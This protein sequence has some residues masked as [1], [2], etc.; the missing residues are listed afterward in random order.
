[1]FLAWKQNKRNLV[2]VSP[3]WVDA[4]TPP[5]FVNRATAL[6]DLVYGYRSEDTTNPHEGYSLML[7]RAMMMHRD[8][9]RLYTCG[10]TSEGLDL[11]VSS[12]FD[13]LRSL[14]LSVVEAEFNCED[15]GMN[16]IVNAAMDSVLSER[17]QAAPLFVRPLHKIGD[18][19]KM[20]HTGLHQKKS[21]VSTRSDCVNQ[22]NRALWR[23]TGRNLPVQTKLVDAVANHQN[24]SLAALAVRPYYALTTR[25]HKDCFSIMD[26]G[27]GDEACSWQLPRQSDYAGTYS[28]PQL[29]GNLSHCDAG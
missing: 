22:M 3:R 8:Y 25:L 19:G 29:C 23:V 11:T 14:I 5:V 21:H 15:I 16:F 7:T 13:Q 2:G 6:Q 4:Q 27:T 9:L 26:D 1:M 12:R 18:F 10:G 17:E 28:M 24:K 20:G